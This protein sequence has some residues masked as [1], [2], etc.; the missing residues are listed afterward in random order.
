MKTKTKTVFQTG[1]TIKDSPMS[2][3]KDY[4]ADQIAAKLK[5]VKEFEAK[6]G[7]KQVSK[8]WKKWCTDPAYRKREWELRQN[9]AKS[10]GANPNINYFTKNTKRWN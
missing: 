2:Q 8:A 7:E 6:Y 5:Q 9:V 3:Y 1:L 10:I 4:P